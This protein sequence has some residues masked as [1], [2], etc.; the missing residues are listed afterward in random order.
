MPNGNSIK[1]R[2]YKVKEPTITADPAAL[3]RRPIHEATSK[4]LSKWEK[5]IDAILLLFAF[6][7]VFLPAISEGWHGII[8][9]APGIGWI[10]HNLSNI[11]TRMKLIMLLVV[12]VGFLWR[13]LGSKYPEG[14]DHRI[15]GGFPSFRQIVEWE[16]YPRTRGEEVTFWFCAVRPIVMG[17]LWF[18]GFGVIAFFVKK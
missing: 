6:F 2:I 15:N 9:D 14:W 10:F 1:K 17:L 12:F 4:W 7:T 11:T 5:T 18:I 8:V 16:M 3:A 13:A